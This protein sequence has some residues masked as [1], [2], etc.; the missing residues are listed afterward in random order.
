[1]TGLID[2]LVRDGLVT[3]A[4]HADDRR[5]MS[6][7]LTETGIQLLTKIL[8]G[9]F[10]TMAWLLQPLTE[11]ERKTLVGLLSKVQQRAAERP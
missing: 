4:P 3:R 6:V 1:M 10:R 7:C 11:E 5:M 8:P 9:H 2:T